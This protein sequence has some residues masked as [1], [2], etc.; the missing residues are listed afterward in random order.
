MNTYA[1]GSLMRT[2]V[3]ALCVLVSASAGAY[4]GWHGGGWHG[5]G[6]HGGGWHGDGWY[7]G[8]WHDGGW[9]GGGWYGGGVIGAPYY[10][11][12]GCQTIRV[13]NSYGRCWLQQSCY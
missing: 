13:C 6:W 3:F 12:Y 10:Y 7:G 4:G 1:K 8:G 9:H 2:L 11:G 5:D